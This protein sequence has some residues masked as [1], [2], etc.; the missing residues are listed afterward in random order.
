[1]L[2]RIV[3][4]TQIIKTNFKGKILLGSQ[5][6]DIHDVIVN[7]RHAG[8]IAKISSEINNFIMTYF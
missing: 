3:G 6:F 8:D 4:L 7:E 1:M 5:H 2:S